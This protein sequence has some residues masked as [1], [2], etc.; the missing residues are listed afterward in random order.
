MTTKAR[1]DRADIS[2]SID[3]QL[4]QA[5]AYALS[6]EEENNLADKKGIHN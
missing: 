1:A 6:K 4:D 5:I 2:Y 3:T